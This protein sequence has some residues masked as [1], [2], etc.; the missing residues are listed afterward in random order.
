M[1]LIVTV[2]AALVIILLGLHGRPCD[3]L[4]TTHIIVVIVVVVVVIGRAEMSCAFTPLL[5]FL[6]HGLRCGRPHN[7]TALVSLI[8]VVLLVWCSI[9]S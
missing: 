6:S 9:P 3:A 5:G 8:S 2:R 4:A 7:I 1:Q